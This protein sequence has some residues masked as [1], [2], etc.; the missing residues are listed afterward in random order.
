MPQLVRALALLRCGIGVHHSGM[1]PIVREMTEILFS[2]GR[3]QV[4]LATETFAVGVNM[5]ARC[6]VFNGVRKND[7][8]ASAG[9]DP[10]TSGGSPL[11]TAV[12]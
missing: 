12:L 6:V 11:A 4:L 1:L 7:G 10:S 8:R 2:K 3:I 5:P 9:L